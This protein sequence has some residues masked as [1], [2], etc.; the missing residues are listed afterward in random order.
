EYGKIS[1][2]EE[3]IIDEL[4]PGPLTLVVES[5]NKL[6]DNLNEDFV[7]RISSNE[8]ARKLAKDKPIT[9]TS[10]NISGKETSYDV[11]EISSKLK[12]RVDYIIDKGK[13]DPSPTSAIVEIKNGDPI[14][15]RE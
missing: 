1:K 4:M 11:K 2:L 7:F 5:K 8:I 3:K 15:H 10:A 12:E 14:F 9:A 13:L 6:A